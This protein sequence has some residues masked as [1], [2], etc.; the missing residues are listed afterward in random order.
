MLGFWVGGVS[1]PDDKLPGIWEKSYE[2]ALESASASGKLV[3]LDFCSNGIRYKRFVRDSY[4]DPENRKLMARFHLVQIDRSERG[5][6]VK[7]YAYGRPGLA[8]PAV[9]VYVDA[10][11]RE[12]DR[13]M[14]TP[15][16]ARFKE[17]LKAV[18]GAGGRLRVFNHRIDRDPKDTQSRMDRFF[19]AKRAGRWD[20]LQQDAKV[21]MDLL[22]PS[23]EE[24]RERWEKLAVECS[25]VLGGV[26]RQRALRIVEEYIRRFPDGSRYLDALAIQG[27]HLSYMKGRLQEAAASYQKVLGRDPNAGAAARARRFFQKHPEEA[28]RLGLDPVELGLKRVPADKV[29]AWIPPNVA[30]ARAQ[31]EKK[32]IFIYACWPR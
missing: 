30:F 21:L 20:L 2:E 19:W 25:Q 18:L 17:E 31:A 10:K 4:S 29:Y 26:D 14:S 7:K 9:R 12:V 6:L 11:G 8:F 24:D 16:P 3:M 28:A 22:D 27:F 15:S 23:R 13:G 1:N 32:W 5:D